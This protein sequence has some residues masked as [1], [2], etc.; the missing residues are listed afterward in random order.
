MHTNMTVL[1]VN[2]QTSEREE[3]RGEREECV[4]DGEGI[5]RAER[6]KVRRWMR[7]EEVIT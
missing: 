7:I 3:E 1:N 4:S 6:K 5:E 2:R